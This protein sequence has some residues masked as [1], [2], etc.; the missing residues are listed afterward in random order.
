MFKIQNCCIT[1]KN[2]FTFRSLAY[3]SFVCTSPA[4]WPNPKLLASPDLLNPS[5]V[6]HL[7][8]GLLFVRVIAIFCL[9]LFGECGQLSFGCPNHVHKIFF[10]SIY[11]R[12][13]RK[14]YFKIYDQIYVIKVNICCLSLV[15]IFNNSSWDYFKNTTLRCSGFLKN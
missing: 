14:V 5:I 10:L 6:G 4:Y 9:F 2:S 15:Y 13:V 7:L 1:V 8:S 12:T 3:L 11:I